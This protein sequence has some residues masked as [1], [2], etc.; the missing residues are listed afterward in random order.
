MLFCDILILECVPGIQIKLHISEKAAAKNIQH[1][2]GICGTRCK[3]IFSREKKMFF[4][5]RGLGAIEKMILATEVSWAT[6]FLA[7]NSLFDIHKHFIFYLCNLFYVKKPVARYYIKKV[8]V[9]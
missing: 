9:H 2:N 3:E 7:I 8:F 4:C 6:Y 5:Y 1:A